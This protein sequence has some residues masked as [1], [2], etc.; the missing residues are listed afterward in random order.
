MTVKELREALTLYPDEMPVMAQWESCNAYIE[1]NN[2]SIERVSKGHEDDACD[3]LLIDV[4][5]Y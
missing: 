1:R 2:L 3:V 4:N 5:H